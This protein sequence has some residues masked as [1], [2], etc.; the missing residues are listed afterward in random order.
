MSA[1]SG[2]FTADPELLQRVGAEIV[3]LAQ[4]VHGTAS[5]LSGQS[6]ALAG[7]NDGFTCQQALVAC[8]RAWEQ[9]MDALGSKL[10]LDG[11]RVD[12]C[13]KDYANADAA[14]YESLQLDWTE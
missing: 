9:A 6:T 5:E 10:A 8:E 2:G 14:A 11:D 13:G 12:L 1:P 7:T 4:D 3:E